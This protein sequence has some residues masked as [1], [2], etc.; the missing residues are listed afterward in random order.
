MI[1][2]LPLIC[3]PQ[4]MKVAEVREMLS[5]ELEEN[6]SRLPNNDKSSALCLVSIDLLIVNN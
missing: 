4:T 1:I 3:N 5:R 6:S 2:I